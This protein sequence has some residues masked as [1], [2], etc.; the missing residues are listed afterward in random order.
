MFKF[1]KICAAAITG[2]TLLA[3]GNASATVITDDQELQNWTTLQPAGGDKIFTLIDYNTFPGDVDAI[4]SWNDNATPLDLTDDV[5]SLTLGGASMSSLAAGVYE[6]RYSI[7]ITGP[8]FFATAALDSTHAANDVS[9]TKEVFSD[10]AF[11][12]SI[13]N[14]LNSMNGV[15]DPANAFTAPFQTIYVRD[16]LTISNGGQLESLSNTFTQTEQIINAVPE[17]SSLAL[18]G[19]GGLGM[20]YRL[21]RRSK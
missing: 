11:T 9:I 17:P 6:L 18:L 12:N 4:A 16:T 10:A 5:Y 19:L 3:A 14:T 7:A 2:L 21:R 15:P 8:M 13:M 1:Q 20:I